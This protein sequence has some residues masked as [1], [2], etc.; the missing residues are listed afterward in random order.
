MDGAPTYGHVPARAPRIDGDPAA[1]AAAEHIVPDLEQ[2]YGSVALADRG[3]YATTAADLPIH[4]RVRVA[5]DDL[6]LSVR[7][8]RIAGESGAGF[9]V[10]SAALRC[11][12]DGI[13]FLA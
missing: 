13:G 3:H 7:P 11:Q 9:Q 5:F 8:D 4:D 10:A 2:Q 1:I 6:A 12:R